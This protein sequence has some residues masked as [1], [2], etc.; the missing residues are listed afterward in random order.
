MALLRRLANLFRRS[1]MDHD[2]D[3]EL[4]AHIEMRIEDNLAAGLTAENAR[5]DALLRFGNPVATR[6][7]VTAVDATLT[8]TSVL[9]DMRYALRQLRKAPVFAITTILTLTLG[10]GAT[11]AI[12]SVMNA[13]L[14][15]LLPVANP[16]QLFYLHVPDGQPYGAHS[17]GD[18]E[19]SFSLPAFNILRQKRH[20]FS[21]VMAFAPLSDGKLAIRFGDGLP[22]EAV[23][24]MVSG[25]FFSGL[26]VAAGSGHLLTM[27]DEDTNAPVAVLS[28]AYWTSRFSRNPSVVG[29]TMY[30]KGIPFTIVGV[31]AVGFPGVEQGESTDL[32]I[33]LQRRPELAPWGNPL[34][35][36][37]YG[38]PDWWCLRVL[39]RLTPGMSARQAIAEVNPPFQA[40]AYARMAAPNGVHPRITLSAVAAKGLV[41]L[42]DFNEYGQRIKVLMA[43][44]TLVLVI[45][46]SNVAMLIMARNAA[47]QRDFS[48]RLALGAGRS[49]LLR[50]LLVESGMLVVVGSVGGWLFGLSATRA[51]ALWAHLKL[52]LA[53]DWKVLLFTSTVSILAALVFALAPMHTVTNA[54]VTSALRSTAATSYQN[55]R[56]GSA[57]LTAQIALCFT[58]LTAAGLL[59]RT[60][61]NYEHANLGM[62]TREL[63]V[64][65][66]TPQKQTTDEA[67]LRFYRTLLER[68]RSLPG[69]KAVTFVGN[70]LGSGWSSN[71]EPRVDGITYSFSQVPLRS[72]VVGPDYLRT[73][74][75]PLLEGRDIRDSDTATSEHVV[76]VNETFVKKLLPN[77]NPIGH[78]LGDPEKDHYTIVGVATD[79]KY[80]SVDEAPRAMAYYPYTQNEDARSTLQVELRTVGNP[81]ALLPTVERALHQMDANLPLEQPMT[82][83]AVFED[84][85]AQQRL[86]SRLA[87]FFALLAAFLV[88][89]GLYG[90]MAYRVNRK[91]VEIGV[92]MA[93]GAQRS[94]VLYLVLRETF[95]IAV[96]G[97][98]A[99]IPIALI[100]GH[101][102]GS[103]LYELQPYDRLS[104]VAAL[105][106]IA[107]VS[108]M[109]G[110]I[111]AHRAA[112]INP[113]QAL[114]S[115]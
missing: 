51:L 22:E 67:R 53:P 115:E 93:M 60:L 76:V 77:T 21:D 111:P 42:G 6:E 78:Q 84:S 9:F 105:L 64:F 48:L 23:G 38:S 46:C 107:G 65:G 16:K 54:P 55:K 83:A 49:A 56:G 7:R 41:G 8:L 86:F 15:R 63:L 59:L 74:G 62:Q 12:F 66:I 3:E 71:D 79:S 45:A 33:P 34:D 4:K 37:L 113:V 32:W 36:T 70:R 96:L 50:Q 103:M 44:V 69:V 85:Y 35:Q 61:L 110:L 25:N 24:D 106:G 57:V 19:T 14:L 81:I 20:A 87:M 88:G 73:L 75:I 97:T 52:N 100:V 11:T 30:L 5:R 82:Q 99:G 102:M 68:M 39:A 94:Q 91:K 26:G 47:R 108:L 80:R 109:A 92:R 95:Q 98:A 31:A 18:S 28:Y 2:I 27:A 1:R 114:R 101:F 89:I 72:N 13:V 40:E 112:S 10:I 104:L 43:L 29:Q 17:T 90:T 58:L